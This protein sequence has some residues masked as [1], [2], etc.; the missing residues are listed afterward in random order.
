MQT[1]TNSRKRRRYNDPHETASVSRGKL[2]GKGPSSKAMV[3]FSNLVHKV[4]DDPKA[5][6]TFIQSCTTVLRSTGYNKW[7]IWYYDAGNAAGAGA[8]QLEFFTPR[9]IKDA[10]GVLFNGKVPAFNSFADVTEGALK[11]LPAPTR[12]HVKSMSATFRFKNVSQHKSIVEMFICGGN[13]GSSTSG[14]P[15]QDF[16]DALDSSRVML[17][18][19]V[20]SNAGDYITHVNMPISLPEAFTRMW[21]VEK[22]TFEFE[23]GEEAVHIMKGKP[24]YLFNGSN[25]LDGSSVI[26][27]PV[28][29]TPS[30][31]GCGKIVFFRII[32]EAT[33]TTSTAGD[34]D[35]SGFRYQ[36]CHPP[37][38]TPSTTAVGGVIVTMVRKY[39]V[40]EPEDHVT[41]LGKDILVLNNNYH[42]PDG[43]IV[44]I[45]IDEDQPQ[46]IAAVPL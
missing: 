21:N 7:Q 3:K 14:S 11:N 16:Q 1:P 40:A 28:W 23:P 22:V 35:A 29:L 42:T 36:V 18:N 13:D 46:T 6:G 41:G 12:V 25:K 4:V 24:N 8:A 19:G 30:M 2:R 32:N 37:H 43:T 10:E 38:V 17:I 26:G 9:Q 39:V 27:S 44:D 45:E 15:Y 5:V 31:A 34:V 33:L 20:T